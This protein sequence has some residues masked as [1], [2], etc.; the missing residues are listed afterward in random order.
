M[1]RG[2]ADPGRFIIRIE[3]MFE[4]I[5]EMVESSRA[6]RQDL[7]KVEIKTIDSFLVES[8]GRVYGERR[9]LI[10]VLRA[11]LAQF[12]QEELSRAEER[13]VKAAEKLLDEEEVL[14]RKIL[15]MVDPLGSIG[16]GEPSGE[17][18]DSQSVN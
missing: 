16:R 7:E 9:R 11:K 8:I 13:K 12:R 18:D 1:A 6:Q 14:A 15:A 5:R 3:G 10:G 2:K 17:N 4:E